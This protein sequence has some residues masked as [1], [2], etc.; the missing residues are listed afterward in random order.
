VLP[1]VKTYGAAVIIGSIDED[2][3]QAQAITRERKLAIAVRAHAYCTQQWAF[4]RK[5]WPSTRWCSPA[6][7]ATKLRR[8]RGRDHRRRSG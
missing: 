8:Q 2:K 7:P 3:Q 4:P 1:L 6:R 5:T